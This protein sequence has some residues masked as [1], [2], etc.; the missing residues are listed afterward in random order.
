M[1]LVQ[2]ESAG[3][4]PLE[5][6]HSPLKLRSLSLLASSSAVRSPLSSGA[7]SSARSGKRSLVDCRPSLNQSSRCT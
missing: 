5:L 7:T 1:Q 4:Q 6:L 2:R 3:Q